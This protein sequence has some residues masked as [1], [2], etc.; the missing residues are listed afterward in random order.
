MILGF[1]SKAGIEQICPC[2]GCMNQAMYKVIL[3]GNLLLA[4]F[5]SD[6]VPQLKGLFFPAGQWPMPYN[7]AKWMEDH[8]IKTLSWPAQSPDL[9]S[10]ENLWK[11]D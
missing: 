11:G 5:C 9:N 7:Q 3:E 10:I 8:Q 1:F 4:F 6:N 2:E